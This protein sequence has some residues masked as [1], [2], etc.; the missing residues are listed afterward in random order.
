[1]GG[2]CVFAHYI[3][4]RSLWETFS[5]N[6]VEKLF[7]KGS[8]FIFYANEYVQIPIRDR[9]WFKQHFYV[10]YIPSKK[11]RGLIQKLGFSNLCRVTKGN[12]TLVGVLEGN[13]CELISKFFYK[14][15]KIHKSI[16]GVHNG[17]FFPIHDIKQKLT[18]SLNKIILIYLCSSFYKKSLILG[19]TRI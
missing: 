16:S 8:C 9:L 2:V 17:F 1:M 10:L 7:R 6:C 18:F 5:Y 12:L 14:L 3:L 4:M 11:L 13:F 19:N 15:S